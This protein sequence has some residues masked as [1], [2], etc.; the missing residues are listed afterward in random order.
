[1]SLEL[2]YK[3][4][5]IGL[6]PGTSTE[7]VLE[8]DILDFERIGQGVSW[9]IRIP[10]SGND[11]LPFAHAA[12]PDQF[13]NLFQTYDGF[14]I[15]VDGYVWFEVSFALNDADSDFANGQLTSVNSTFVENKDKSIRELISATIPFSAG[16]YDTIIKA[17]NELD[18][19]V[20]RFPYLHFW[21]KRWLI[22]PGLSDLSIYEIAN[23]GN[24][25][26]IP[27]FQIIYL[28]RQALEEMGMQLRN[29]FSD[30]SGGKDFFSQLYII[31]NRV[32]EFDFSQDFEIVV[33]DHIPDLT[34]SDL[35]RDLA[36][37]SGSSVHIPSNQDTVEIRSIAKDTQPRNIKTTLSLYE[38]NMRV[39]KSLLSNLK[40]S[41]KMSDDEQ[42]E[43]QTVK[44]LEG[45]YLGEFNTLVDW[46]AGYGSYVAEDYGFIKSLGFYRKI[47]QNKSGILVDVFYSYPFQGY[48]SGEEKQK[49][50][51]PSLLPVQKD[52]YRYR[53]L[54]SNFEIV[55]NG[56][57][58]VRI[59][60]NF[61]NWTDWAGA[62]DYIKFV[63]DGEDPIYDTIAEYHPIQ[64]YDYGAGYVDLFVG[65]V[66]DV[67]LERI[68]I[69][70]ELNYYLPVI[71]GGPHWPEGDQ[72]NEDFPGRVLIYHGMQPTIDGLATYPYASADCYD[73][74]GAQIAKMNLTF[75]GPTPNLVHD[76]WQPIL[77]FLNK[78]RYITLR[79]Y[80]SADK[81]L[82]V[83][84][85]KRAKFLRGAFRFKRLRARL[86]EN[87]VE[88][89][90][91]EGWWI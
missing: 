76:V 40:F 34:L 32:K 18:D 13:E 9:P 42:L 61:G 87:G 8:D 65:Y 81:L 36:I 82:D 51:T 79:T 78:A 77:S 38:E 85:Q 63:E 37:Y 10:W 62:D 69:R 28:L 11:H 70:K 29:R 21:G 88:D 47:V 52:R 45:N 91:L 2:R 12:D 41:W 56:S 27:G 4:K 83:Y 49:E 14:T 71:S 25:M 20:I 7:W 30:H 89:Q 57:G 68:I 72:N 86:G 16:N 19:S 31:H 3:N 44:Q 48:S 73:K 74:D 50:L 54:E 80:E 24:G 39:Q 6:L 22:D 84:R 59:T 64:S 5:P 33:K 90:E 35:I 75:A 60:G 43:A 58:N 46:A 1:V 17:T 26:I 23:L 53:E 55:N 15:S 67:S 66:S